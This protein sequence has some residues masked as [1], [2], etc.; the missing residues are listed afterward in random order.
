MVL[1]RNLVAHHIRQW[2][3][4]RVLLGWRLFASGSGEKR[5]SNQ[6]HNHQGHMKSCGAQEEYGGPRSQML[7][8]DQEQQG[9]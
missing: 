4:Q 6:V 9:E 3:L 1:T 7:H 8:C 2:K 5:L